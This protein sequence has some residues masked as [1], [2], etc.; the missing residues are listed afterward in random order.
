ME[1]VQLLVLALVQG[2]TEFLPVSSSAHLVLVPSLTGWVDQGIAIDVATHLGTLMAV[3]LYF[4]RDSLAMVRGVLQVRRT[5]DDERLLL[6]V[7]VATVPV[8]AVGVLVKDFV[9][10]GLRHASVVAWT[11]L[12]FGLLL[13]WADRRRG[14][15]TVRE[16]S[17]SH[18]LLVGLAQ[19]LALLPGVSRSGVTVTAALFLG[20]S[21]PE[22]MRF[23]LL[24][25][26]PTIVAASALI[27][28]ELHQAGAWL[29]T[30]DLLVAAGLA[31]AAALLAISGLMGW[32]RKASFT[33]FVL[34]R[35]LL[36]G[37][38]LVWLYG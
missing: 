31:F 8:V 22:A 9:E 15:R 10:S 20:Y 5:V 16:M 29:L 11:T 21:R 33:P 36:G 6:K 23:S 30:G 17:V 28:F 14:L 25:S 13:Y 19:V 26:I 1:F 35:L 7:A 34:Y 32:L 37:G 38:L 12:V 24:L 3:L 2:V 18:A 4:R 27:V